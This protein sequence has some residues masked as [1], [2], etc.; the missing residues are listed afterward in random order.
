MSR[1]LNV[2]L[3]DDS[4]SVLARQQGLLSEIDGVHVVGTASNGAEA[5]RVVDACGPD[6]VLMDIV[7]PGMDGLAALRMLMVRHP[8]LRVVMVS[9]AGGSESRANEAFRLG[10]CQVLSKPVDTDQFEAL[11]ARERERLEGLEAGGAR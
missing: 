8:D 5:L 9:S 4:K 3:V 2:V 1:K 11:V 6:L 10:A 7:M